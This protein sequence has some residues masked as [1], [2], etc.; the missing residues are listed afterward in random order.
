MARTPILPGALACAFSLPAAAVPFSP[1]AAGWWQLQDPTT[2]EQ[3]CTASAPCDV[4]PGRYTLIDFGASPARRTTVTV[5]GGSSGGGASG[6]DILAAVRSAI[7]VRTRFCEIDGFTPGETITDCEIRCPSAD[8]VPIDLTCLVSG[9]VRAEIPIAT[10][11]RPDAPG[12]Y[13]YVDGE[14]EQ[15]VATLV[16]L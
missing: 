8:Q 13:C 2:Y 14:T 12:G 6:A 10:V 5:G 11:L 9:N 3:L 1:D 15:I 16:C 7:T 4:P